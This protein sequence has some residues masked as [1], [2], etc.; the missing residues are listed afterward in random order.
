[1]VFADNFSDED[2]N[3][4]TPKDA[5]M[6]GDWPA[7]Q[8]V[9]LAF[10]EKDGRTEMKLTHTGFPPEMVDDCTKGWNESFDKLDAS[11]AKA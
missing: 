4:I 3:T 1:L 6:P 9:T 8:E 2:G 5:G 7:K 11:L 10:E